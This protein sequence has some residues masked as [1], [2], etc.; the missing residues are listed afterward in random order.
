MTKHTNPPVNAALVLVQ[1]L[2]ADHG[3][4]FKF[5]LS[6]RGRLWVTLTHWSDSEKYNTSAEVDPFDVQAAWAGALA[7]VAAA[8]YAKC[9][10]GAAHVDTWSGIA[11]VA[12]VA[13]DAAAQCADYLAVPE[14]NSPLAEPPAPA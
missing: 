2:V 14:A 1:S 11:G 8:H 3:D 6:K 12:E 4:T 10:K 13:V 9:F 5:S 7:V